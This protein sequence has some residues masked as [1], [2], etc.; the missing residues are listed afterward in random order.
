VKV[1]RRPFDAEDMH[2]AESHPALRAARRA[3]GKYDTNRDLFDRRRRV[4][5]LAAQGQSD[6]EIARATGYTDRSVLRIRQRPRMVERPAPPDG[7]A[8]SAKRVAELERTAQLALY[9]AKLIR[10]EDPC[11]VWET[12]STLSRLQLQELAV[13]ALCAS[14]ADGDP[15]A[16]VEN[17]APAQD[18]A[19]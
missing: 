8:V 12:L 7:A 19:S 9:L 15:L 13:I 17:L 1:P 14:P 2:P 18:V 3:L 11:L 6:E 10:D 16:W 4:H 5:R